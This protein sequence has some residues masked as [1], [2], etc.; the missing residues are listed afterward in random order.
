MSENN[1]QNATNPPNVNT[2]DLQQ[3]LAISTSLTDPEEPRDMR[4]VDEE[5]RTVLSY[6]IIYR[7]SILK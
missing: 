6:H 3:I 1:F 4:P 5:V 2:S 7:L